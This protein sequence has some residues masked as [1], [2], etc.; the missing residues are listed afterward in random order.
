LAVALAEMAFAG[1]CGAKI[2]LTDVP[3]NDSVA[4]RDSDSDAVLLYS[5]SASRFLVEVAPRNKTAFEAILQGAQIP[6]GQVGE[7]VPSD[8]LQ[9]ASG[10]TG[11]ASSADWLIDAAL[12][13]LKEAWQK[14]LRW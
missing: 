14:P 8:R 10:S 1:G 2:R 4:A 6:F 11:A 3:R 9:I 5:E 12:A 7:V 13:D